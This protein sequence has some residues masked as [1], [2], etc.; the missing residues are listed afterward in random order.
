MPD[1]ELN[2][3]QIYIP[4]RFSSVHVFL[5]RKF[6]FFFHPIRSGKILGE[7]VVGLSPSVSISISHTCYKYKIEILKPQEHFHIT[8]Q[9]G[10]TEITGIQLIQPSPL[11]CR[12]SYLFWLSKG[13]ILE[14]TCSW[15]YTRHEW[16]YDLWSFDCRI[17][18][19]LPLSII[20]NIYCW[21]FSQAE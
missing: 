11:Y 3:A 21:E 1:L 17:I 5:G 13:L 10:S 15:I 20:I 12:A 4:V 18:I 6:V 16:W 9:P 19:S 2:L 8:L 14:M 7:S